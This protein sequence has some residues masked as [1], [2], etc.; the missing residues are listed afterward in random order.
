MKLPGV[1]AKMVS[2]ELDSKEIGLPYTEAVE[3]WDV[4]DVCDAATWI[5]PK[6]G[7]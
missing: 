4:C 1:T 2:E 7:G 5:S 3:V 6:P